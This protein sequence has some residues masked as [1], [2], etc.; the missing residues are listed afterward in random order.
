ME[1]GLGQNLAKTF[2]YIEANDWWNTK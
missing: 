2:R 1:L